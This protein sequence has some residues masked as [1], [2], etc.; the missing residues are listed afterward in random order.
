[1]PATFADLKKGDTLLEK[2]RE[3]GCA[4][5]TYYSNGLSPWHAILWQ[6]VTVEKTSSTSYWVNGEKYAKSANGKHLPRKTFSLPQDK[7]DNLIPILPLEE[8]ERIEALYA[9]IL[10]VATDYPYVGRQH[11]LQLL[12]QIPDLA[13]ASQIAQKMFVANTE[14]T[15]IHGELF[16]LIESASS[17][18]QG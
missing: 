1:M 10:R 3:V 5:M 7:E 8:I 13:E 12:H 2:I 18:P 9:D 6:P 11:V 14:L 16:K 17:Q 4:P 15:R